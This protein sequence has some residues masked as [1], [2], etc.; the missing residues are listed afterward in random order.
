MDTR[1]PKLLATLALFCACAGSPHDESKWV[2]P[3]PGP[4][5]VQSIVQANSKCEGCHRDIAK[6]WQ[7]SRHH[8]AATNPQYRA[9]YVIEPFAFCQACHAPGANNGE[10]VGPLAELGVGC[11]SCHPSIGGAT[12]TG[13]SHHPLI[14]LSHA[15]V[16]SNAY[17]LA[18]ACA[19]CHEFEFPAQG[20]D[21]VAFMQ[22]TVSEHANSPF[23][24]TACADCHMPRVGSFGRR[25]RSHAFA[26]TRDPVQL[27]N[28]MRIEVT[29]RE[30]TLE[31]SMTLNHVGHAF[32]TGDLFRRLTVE[33]RARDAVGV[34]KSLRR[35]YLSRHF[36]RQHQGHG[37]MALVEVDDDRP[38]LECLQDACT[39][40]TILDLG[41]TARNLPFEFNVAYE[42]VQHL[43]RGS[44][45]LAEVAERV[46]LKEG[47]R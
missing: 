20:R 26:G 42:R 47:K 40:R 31:F 32:P 2:M 33:A 41:V 24:K 17:S 44:E 9:A 43:T 36:A 29:R 28:A 7:S 19:S 10:T 14:S 13:T 16:R 35:R 34:V 25:H 3:G 12:L 37:G 1:I 8:L 4:I 18:G 23:A 27:R 30:Q 22:R 45:D 11:L 6:E 15:V 5:H 38:G 39:I 46:I 21:A